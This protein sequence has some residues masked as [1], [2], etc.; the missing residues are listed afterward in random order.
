MMGKTTHAQVKDKDRHLTVSQHESDA[1]LIPMA[2]LAQLKELHPERMDWV[3][4]E[5]TKE[6]DFRRNETTRVNTLVFTERVIGIAS[7]LIIGCI[8]LLASYSLAMAGHDWVAGVIGGT[9]VVGLVS[10]FV[11]GVRQKNT[12]SK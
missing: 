11:I 3:F 9:T 10:A 4:V 8:S 12:Q 5:S 7:G 1:P 6:G 2:Q